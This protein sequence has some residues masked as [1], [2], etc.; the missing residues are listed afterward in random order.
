MQR[1]QKNYLYIHLFRS[2]SK[3]TGTVLLHPSMSHLF[4]QKGVFKEIFENIKRMTAFKFTLTCNHYPMLPIKLY[5][6]PVLMLV[7][8]FFTGMYK[9]F[10]VAGNKTWCSACVYTDTAG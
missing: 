7:F 8:L 10:P 6:F 1:V 5:K 2:K 4:P 3:F 9:T